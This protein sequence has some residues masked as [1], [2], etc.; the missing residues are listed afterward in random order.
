LRVDPPPLRFPVPDRLDGHHEVIV[1]GGGQAGLA[2]SWC[3]RDQGVEHVVL[4]R[5]RVGHAWREERWDAFCLVT[6]NWQCQLPGHPYPGGDPDG[7]MVKE[8]IIGY[9]DRYVD[10]AI[11][12]LHEGVRVTEIAADGDGF[13]VSTS[14][15]TLSADR[16]V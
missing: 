3:L 8:E 14:H 9:L 12:P 11:P 2:V 10:S 7:F 6:P 4:E 16:V 13:R 15:G 5:H 1:V